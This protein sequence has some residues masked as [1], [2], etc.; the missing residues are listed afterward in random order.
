[1]GV[2][3]NKCPT[4]LAAGGGHCL[5]A[6]AE[7]QQQQQFLQCEHVGR[8]EQQQC[9]Q[10]AWRRPRISCPLY[11]WRVSRSNSK[12][13]LRERRGTSRD[14]M[15]RPKPRFPHRCTDACRNAKERRSDTPAGTMA[16]VCMAEKVPTSVSCAAG[17][18]RTRRAARP[19]AAGRLP[20]DKR[21][22]PGGAL[23]EKEGTAAGTQA[24]AHGGAG[25]AGG[26]SPVRQD[27]PMRKGLLP[28][29]AVENQ[30]TGLRGGAVY[31]DSVELPPCGK[32]GM[33]SAAEAD[34][35]L[36]D[37]TGQSPAHRRAPCGRQAGA[38]GTQPVRPRA[39]LRTRHDL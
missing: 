9:Q 29:R 6:L 33:A 1:M 34:T 20:Y 13:T 31:A 27:V 16:G 3:L 18:Q 36:R 30:H 7:C 5:A 35:L 23:S 11:A 39:L 32:R 26:H 37:G 28:G 8:R 2:S 21:G 4:V 10:F 14:G 22:A 24:A 17:E 15:S 19:G 38:E 12:R 25:D